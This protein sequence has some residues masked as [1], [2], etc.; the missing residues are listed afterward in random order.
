MRALVTGATGFV[1]SHV[2]DLLVAQGD[3]VTA[4]VRSPT[5]AERLGR[6]G[7]RLVRGDLADRQALARAAEGQEVVFHVAGA[8]AALDEAGYLAANRQGTANLVQAMEAAG[9]RRLVFLSSMAAG[10]PSRPGAPRIGTEPPQPVTA[11][12]RSK[13]AAEDVVRSSRLSWTILRPPTVYGPRDRDNLIRL[14]RLA[15]LG[16]A[17]VFGTG[18]Q[19]LSLV[20]APDLAEATLAATADATAGQL[21]YVNH[22]QVVTS[23]GLVRAVGAAMHRRVRVV[24]LPTALGRAALRLTGAVASLRRRPTILNADKAN[25]FFQ[26][27]WTGDPAPFTRDTAWRARRALSE[28]LDE[29]VRWYRDAGWL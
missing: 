14:F 13:L 25:E 27:A 23:A 29:T 1:G 20:Y 28:G 5:K 19:E 10:G 26:P 7:V 21:Y 11:Y 17:P 2:A 22:P 9:T 15:R 12:G 3:T 4:L 8:V 18:D 6:S 24:P 16:I